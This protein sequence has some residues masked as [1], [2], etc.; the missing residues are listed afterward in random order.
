MQGAPAFIFPWAAGASA[1]PFFPLDTA[2]VAKYWMTRLVFTVLPAPD[3][4]LYWT[5]DMAI[6]SQL[7]LQSVPE[8]Y[9]VYTMQSLALY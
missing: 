5:E 2:I 4:P 9:T 8:E 7:Q 1:A 3:S 6:F